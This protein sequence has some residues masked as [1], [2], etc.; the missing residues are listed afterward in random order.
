M[1]FPKEGRVT[2]IKSRLPIL[3][4]YVML[5][6]PMPVWLLRVSRNYREISCGVV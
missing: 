6:F 4:N 2:L 1:Y 5:I 3:P